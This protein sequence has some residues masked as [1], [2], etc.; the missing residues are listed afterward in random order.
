MSDDVITITPG[1]QPRPPGENDFSGP[2][3]TYPVILIRVSDAITEPSSGQ[4]A[5]DYVYRVWTLA[6]DTPGR[7]YDGQVLDT[8]ATVK[9]SQSSKQYG[10]ISAFLGRGP[11]VG[12]QLS[13][14]RDLVGRGA[15][16]D[17]RTNDAGYPQIFAVMAAPQAPAASANR[18]APAA[19]VAPRQTR[20][21][22]P[23][24][25]VAD[26]YAGTD[27]DGPPDDDPPLPF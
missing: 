22:V 1:R 10:L 9:A 19:P 7:E 26:R 20:G 11:A 5:G 13:L 12:E 18:R 23:V 3:G 4:Y 27:P 15:L 16:A 6:I 17:I 21:R 2:D 8:R 24:A 25:S 14:S